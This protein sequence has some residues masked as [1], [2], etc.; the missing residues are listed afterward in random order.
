[1]IEIQDILKTYFPEYAQ[2]H[3]LPYYYYKVINALISCRTQ[4]LGSHVDTC[5]DCGHSEVSYNSCRNRH[6]PKCQS[7]AT[8]K[9]VDKQ[10]K[11]LL[12]IQ[13]FHIVFTVPD[14]LN[15]LFQYNLTLFYNLLFKTV[16]ETLFEL[17]KDKKRLGADI[18]FTSILHTWSQTLVFHPHLHCIVTGGGLNA[19]QNQFIHSKN[20]FLF[21]VKVIS[22]T[23]RK[24]F[25]EQL[26]KMY[27]DTPSAFIFPPKV[28]NKNSY[29][30]KMV[31]SLFIFKWVVFAKATFKHAGAVLKY[32]GRYTHRIA[33]SN[34]RII[35]MD[36]G[37]ISFNYKDRKDKDKT[38]VM[39]L[40]AD[41][42]IRRFLMHI[43]PS[44]FVKIRHYGILSNASRKKKVNL[45][46]KLIGISAFLKKIL[47]QKTEPFKKICP[48]C[49]HGYLV[50]SHKLN[51]V[52]LLS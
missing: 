10:M 13:Y 27:K 36:N 24:K 51:H 23:F 34:E 11:A 39:T 14:T 28:I 32:L 49:K 2:K 37:M 48:I 47:N 50:F 33:I 29:F 43:L 20:K 38:K 42:F 6:C 35:S 12:P 1:M 31:D 30:Y 45:I 17:A 19:L 5:D 22:A 7:A 18:G 44:G 4:A 52:R 26:K 25:T 9:W 16:S 41:E 46:R 21:P 3:K 15:E 40:T 8:A